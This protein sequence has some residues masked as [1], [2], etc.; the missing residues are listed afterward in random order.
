MNNQVI[1]QSGHRRIST[2]QLIR[3]VMSLTMFCSLAPFF[4]WTNVFGG[5]GYLLYQILQIINLA[6]VCTIINWQHMSTNKF[7]AAISMIALFLFLS[8]CT[9][10]KGGTYLPIATGNVV[11]FLTFSL[12]VMADE[13]CIAESFDLLKTIT[14]VVLAYALIIFVLVVIGVPIPAIS[15]QSN[16]TGRT[17]VSGQY[18]MNYLGCLFIRSRF[19]FRMDR[20]TSVFTEPGVVG[21]ITA[22][23]LAASDFDLKKDKRNV[24]LF[25]AGICSLS[26]AFVF[27]IAILIIARSIR[28]GAYKTVGVVA[29]AIVMY[30]VFMSVNFT[31]PYLADFQS[32][33]IV[34]EAGLA[35]NDRISEYAQTQ[36]ESFLHSDI[37]TVLF[38]Y[39]NAYVN[40]TTNINFWQGSATYKRQIFQFGVI[41]FGLY[42]IWIL[43]APYKCYKTEEKDINARMITYIAVFVASIYQRPNLTTLFFLYFLMAGCL[44]AKNLDIEAG[45]LT[46]GEIIE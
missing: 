28:R 23:F 15:M 40:P 32:R 20:F 2:R 6:L 4:V 39:G 24:I 1:S 11:T 8:L 41:G 16:E 5:I 30:F 26:L 27:L 38:G 14:T 22:F 45:K 29:L 33:L 36:F 13:E 17:A 25:V 35:G 19:I 37:K 46:C 7:V 9:G 42:L 18:Y 44:Y 43:V 12:L 10:V 34:T 31:N 3:V 21:T